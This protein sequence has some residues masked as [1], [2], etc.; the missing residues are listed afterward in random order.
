MTSPFR[1]NKKTRKRWRKSAK[2][3][4]VL[5]DQFEKEGTKPEFVPSLRWQADFCNRLAVAKR[6]KKKSKKSK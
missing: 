2:R 5:A 4:A 6:R 1:H 3:A